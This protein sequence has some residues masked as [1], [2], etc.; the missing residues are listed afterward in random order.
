MKEGGKSS[1]RRTLI[2][3]VAVHRDLLYVRTTRLDGSDTRAGYYHRLRKTWHK[4]EHMPEL[5]DEEKATLSELCLTTSEE[6][7]NE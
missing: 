4:A 7:T 3:G 6:K 5:T 2:E 1:K